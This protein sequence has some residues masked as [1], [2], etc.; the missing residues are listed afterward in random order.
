[1]N[2]QWAGTLEALKT[3]LL[4]QG[5]AG[6]YRGLPILGPRDVFVARFSPDGSTLMYST[7]IGGMGREIATAVHLDPAGRVIVCGATGSADFSVTPG[8]YQPAHSG[9]VAT[10]EAWVVALSSD[11]SSLEYGTFLGKNQNDV[12]LCLDVDANGVIAV[13]GYTWSPGFPT[14]P[15]AEQVIHGGGSDVFLARLDTTRT[16]QAQLLYSTFFGG[17][18]NEDVWGLDLVDGTTAII[19]GATDSQDLP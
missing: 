2:F 6:A 12:A 14:T 1:M 13:G 16:G 11:G 7:L 8:A 17:S 19:A 4:A 5:W 18:A 10:Q 15:G 3:T 9:P